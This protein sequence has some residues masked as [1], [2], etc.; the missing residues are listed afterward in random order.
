MFSFA[1]RSTF[2]VV[3]FCTAPALAQ[4]KLH[5]VLGGSPG[6]NLGTDVAAVGDVDGDGKQD[7]IGGAPWPFSGG[8]NRYARVYSGATGATLFTFTSTV[9][10]DQFAGTVAS[11]GDVDADGHPDFVVGSVYTTAAD[12]TGRAQVFSGLDGSLIKT[13]TG[14]VD[15][16][17]FGAAPVAGVGDLDGDAHDDVLVAEPLSSAGAAN[18][19]R[20][21]VYSSATWA[22][23]YE[24]TGAAVERMG[25]SVAAA[26]DVNADGVPDFVVGGSPNSNAHVLGHAWVFSGADGSLLHTFV[27]HDEFDS[28]GNAVSGVGDVDGDGHD[29]V[30]V[31]AQLD[32]TVAPQAGKATVYSGATGGVLHTVFGA[33]A[34]Q[35]FG[36]D[37]AAA[38]DRDGDG[39]DDFMVSTDRDATIAAGTGSATIYSGLDGHVLYK[40]TSHASNDGF[41]VAIAALGDVDGDGGGDY[42]VGANST[43]AV[44][45]QNIGA[46]HVLSLASTYTNYCTSTP[47]STGVPA[48]LHGSGY[49]TWSN[50]DLVLTATNLPL[51][52][53]GL[54]IA[55]E[56]QGFSPLGNGHLCLSPKV[57]R[58][59]PILSS[60]STGTITAP[61]S[62]NVS[63]W[64]SLL[65]PG[66]TW[67][68]QFWYRDPAAGGAGFNVTDAVQVTFVP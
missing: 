43:D 5:T 10:S 3:A 15:P 31:A 29:D 6:D 50:N 56:T 66:E 57:W 19:G 49:G 67:N 24:R 41:G 27:G 58:I 8:A 52:R 54:V 68:L 40:L 65:N 48:T 51:N 36:V 37:V 2:V 23:L 39:F 25:T 20:V 17:F 55:S 60:G 59:V 53:P 1:L 26:G 21:R 61:V 4:I 12:T 42:L 38:G 45:F 47:N 18:G 33:L 28:F 14:D 34:V 64:N 62:H 13:I 63:P 11:V 32:G 30:I 46:V 35:Q 16:N 7:F 44:P 22:V 9:S